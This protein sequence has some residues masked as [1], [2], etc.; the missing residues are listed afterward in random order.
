MARSSKGVIDWSRYFIHSIMLAGLIFAADHYY[1]HAG[2]LKVTLGI[3]MPFMLLLL[4]WHIVQF[5]W[6]TGRKQF[7]ACTKVLGR[8]LTTGELLKFN[9]YLIIFNISGGILRPFI[10]QIPSSFTWIFY[11]IVVTGH[12]I[13]LYLMISIINKRPIKTR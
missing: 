11:G 8:T 1:L 2:F 6:K 7:K 10:E 9:F 12:S 4:L 13:I 5:F 3:V